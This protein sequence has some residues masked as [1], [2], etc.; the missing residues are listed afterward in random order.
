MTLARLA[1]V[2]LAVLVPLTACLVFAAGDVL[3]PHPW[4]K[5]ADGAAHTPVKLPSGVPAATTMLMP[6]VP[7]GPLAAPVSPVA[8]SVTLRPP[9]VPPRV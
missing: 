3:L 1:V 6:L 7:L 2:A 9:F 4:T 5:H 8:A